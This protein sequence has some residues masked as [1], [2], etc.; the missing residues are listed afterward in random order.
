MLSG[1]NWSRVV[2]GC[3]E[4]TLY[5]RGGRGRGFESDRC[6]GVSS[7]DGGSGYMVP[8]VWE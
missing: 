4:G 1:C 8:S 7:K 2:M 5:D 6:S 3:K